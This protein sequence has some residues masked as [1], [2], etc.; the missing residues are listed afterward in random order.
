MSK[1]CVVHREN[2]ICQG[3]LISKLLF[4]AIP[5]RSP[6]FRESGEVEDQLLL[7]HSTFKS[8]SSSL[9]MSSGKAAMEAARERPGGIQTPEKR[10]EEWICEAL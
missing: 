8:C 9:A 3:P 4:P 2:N 6:I 10:I 5:N 7:T 1:N